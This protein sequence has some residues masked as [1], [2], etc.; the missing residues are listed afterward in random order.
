MTV[1][2]VGTEFWIAK[3]KGAEIFKVATLSMKDS[4]LAACSDR[5]DARLI[6]LKLEF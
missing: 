4:V 2:R 3:E 1:L 5:R 6:Q